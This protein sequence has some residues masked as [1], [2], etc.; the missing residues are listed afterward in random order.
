M[1]LPADLA[2][3]PYLQPGYGSVPWSVNGI[4]KEY[5]DWYDFNP[6]GLNPGPRSVLSKALI[7]VAGGSGA[8]VKRAAAEQN[9]Q[10]ALE[11][12]DVVLAGEPSSAEAHSIRR[13]AL[14][15]L[16]RAATNTVERNVY[17]VAALEEK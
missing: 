12:C 13:E 7:E 9:P 2:N 16:G 15:K 17:L 3:L 10:L 1:K 8:I 5:T 4:Y 11:L 14:E 6:A